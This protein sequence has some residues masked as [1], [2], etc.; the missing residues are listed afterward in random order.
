MASDYDYV[1]VKYDNNGNQLWEA[2]YSGPG[3]NSLDYYSFNDFP[4]AIAVDRF[5]NIY[6]TGSSV[7]SGTLSDFATVKYDSAGNE[8]WVARWNGSLDAEEEAIGLLLNDVGN[9]YVTGMANGGAFAIIKY[10]PEQ[11]DDASGNDG[12]ASDSSGG[13]GGGGCFLSASR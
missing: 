3:D 7:G 9:V 12:G 13:G 4:A 11:G 8:I 2:R 10:S 1:L 5:D 6:V